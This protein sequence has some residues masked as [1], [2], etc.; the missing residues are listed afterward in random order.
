MKWNNFSDGN[1]SWLHLNTLGWIKCYP[2]IIKDS[3]Q[4]YNRKTLKKQKKQK[5]TPSV[6]HHDYEFPHKTDR[7]QLYG[8]AGTWNDSSEK[9][10]SN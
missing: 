9:F 8:L 10:Y 4:F 2:Q 7:F 3:T 1:R 6:V 5:A